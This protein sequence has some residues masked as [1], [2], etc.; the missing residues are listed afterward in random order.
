[1]TLPP[2]HHFRMLEVPMR[3]TPASIAQAKAAMLADQ[4][5][6]RQQVPDMGLENCPDCLEPF[7]GTTSADAW[8]KVEAHYAITHAPGAVP[9]H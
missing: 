6:V 8:A 7:I 2:A 1:M 5:L 4:A 3:P 9:R